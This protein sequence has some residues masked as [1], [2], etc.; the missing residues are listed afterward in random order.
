MTRKL[1]P[2]PFLFSLLLLLTFFWLVGAARADLEANET[3][4]NQES[5]YAYEINADSQGLLWVSDNGAGEVRAYNPATNVY[6]TY[7]GMGAPSDARRAADGAV[8]WVDQ[9]NDQLGRLSPGAN[10][11]TRWELPATS[12]YGTAIDSSG[13]VWVT[14]FF[15]PDIYR[16]DPGTS[17]LCTYTYGTIGA[18]DYILAHDS[19]V[20]LGD[21]VNDAIHRLEISNGLLT[22]WKLPFN[23]RPVGLALDRLGNLWFADPD[24]GEL[25]RVE[26]GLDL[27][28]MYDPPTGGTPD[29]VTSSVG[30]IWYIDDT[31]H[32]IGS[33]DPSL[34]APK[35]S[36]VLSPTE[37]T[38]DS[39]CASIS[40]ASSGSVS[41][42]SD[43][44]NWSSASYTTTVDAGG[45][46]ISD[47]PTDAYP[48][49]IAAIPGQVWFVDNGR[50]VLS[51]IVEKSSVTACKLEDADGD[52][53][54]TDD[55]TPYEDWRIYLVVEGERQDP[56]RLTGADGCITWYDLEAGQI[57]GVEE[58]VLEGWKA[59]S[60]TSHS[61][62]VVQMGEMYQHT[63]INLHTVQVTAC[64]LEDADGDLGTAD[65]QTPLPDWP[66]S[67]YINDA[68]QETQVTG[69][70]GCF[71]WGGLLPEA[72][73]KVAEGSLPG[74]LSLGPTS[75]DFGLAVPGDEFEHTFIN[76]KGQAGV[77]L[78][79]LLKV[80]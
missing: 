51:Q 74:W 5:G 75:H 28:T 31:S 39:S 8:W 36:Y 76:T 47:L 4:L 53:G 41:S 32:R 73:Y 55:Q 40:P 24:K 12:P 34:A 80:Y 64:K 13:A 30:R 10:A 14:D 22:T 57:Y 7:L 45:W 37:T 23:A 18:S 3:P 72:S 11:I 54:T 29:M 35:S 6:T 65:D 49:G 9:Q 50:Q 1:L 19:Q 71:N 59:L 25:G 21:W 66:L 48:W 58:E 77:F 60:P 33:L 17:Q 61:F 52:L 46:Q 44:V 79:I 70:D 43:T 15:Q 68:L 78:P 69:P 63:F 20:W 27:L 56:G 26:P 62:G 38:L 16:F 67:L 42:A 2:L